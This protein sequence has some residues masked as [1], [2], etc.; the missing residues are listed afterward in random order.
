MDYG[1]TLASL[2]VERLL[3]GLLTGAISHRACLDLANSQFE[4]L[5]NRNACAVE[6]LL[7][8]GNHPLRV[9]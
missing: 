2:R 6:F 1:R 3:L 8:H 9:P 5:E 4:F 7:L